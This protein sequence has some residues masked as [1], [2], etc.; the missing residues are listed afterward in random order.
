MLLSLFFVRHRNIFAAQDPPVEKNNERRRRE[1][2]RTPGR[3][4]EKEKKPNW[5]KPNVSKLSGS[6]SAAAFSETGGLFCFVYFSFRLD[7]WV[8]IMEFSRC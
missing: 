8:W 3:E 5:H 7:R 2:G 4:R 1:A 6:M